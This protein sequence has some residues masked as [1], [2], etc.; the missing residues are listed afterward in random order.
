MLGYRNGVAQ[1][2]RLWRATTRIRFDHRPNSTTA[3][4]TGCGTTGYRY[5]KNTARG[6]LSQR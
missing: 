3:F 4:R 5:L 1:P 6:S 2:M